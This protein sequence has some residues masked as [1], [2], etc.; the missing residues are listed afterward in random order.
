M[1]RIS[2]LCATA[3]LVA[4]AALAQQSPQMQQEVA[5]AR[6]AAARNAQ[7]LHEYSW[8]STTEILHK[9][10]V[11][12]TTVDSCQYGADGKVVKTELSEPP[13]E[14]AQSSRRRRGRIK[15]KIV[16]KKTG[17]MKEEMQSA[18]ALVQSYVPP[19]AD[20]LQAVVAAG[21][22]TVT[23]SG[24]GQAVVRFADYNKSGDALTLTFDTQS[25]AVQHVSVET[26]LDDPSKAVTLEVTFESLSDGTA[27]PATTVLAI[28]GDEIEVHIENSNYQKVGVPQ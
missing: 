14:P 27:Y 20:K 21:G 10:E 2:V 9:G 24:D 1:R 26:W 17:E 15:E 5:A 22:V 6:E 3:C 25:M 23:P 19:S 13:P 28:P 18:A 11:K 12:N 16:A 4:G 7:A 8:I